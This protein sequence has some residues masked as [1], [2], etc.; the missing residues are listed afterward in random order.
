MAGV[1]LGAALAAPVA[2]A[3]SEPPA[4]VDQQP[5]NPVPVTSND[6]LAPRA[7]NSPQVAADPTD[8]SFLALASRLDAP[9]FSCA[10]HV[11]G[12]GGRSWIPV[13]PV[14]ALPEGAEKCYAPEVAFGP[15]GRLFYLFVGLHGSGNEPMGVFLV[16][17]TDRGRSFSPPR[18]VL[19]EE[20]YQ[21]RLAID[22][23][24]GQA[25]RLYLAWLQA[26]A[27]APLGGLPPPPNPI[28]ASYSDDG[29]QS[30]SEPIRVSDPDRD[31]AVAPALSVAGNGT[32]HV[33]YLDLRE[34]LRDYR[35]VEGPVY[36]GTWSVVAT[37]ST[38]GGKTFAGGVVVDDGLVPA[39]RVML[40]FTMPPP[41][42]TAGQGGRVHVGWD[43]ARHGD[44]DVFVATSRDAGASW[45]D[46]VRV[47][48]DE[49]G[50]GRAQYLPQI[51]VGRD[52]RLH[53]IFYDR[54]HDPTNIFN[55]IAYTYSSDGGR[56][57]APTRRLTSHP[58]DSRIGQGY[59]VVSAA[60]LIEFGSRL[61][62]EAGPDRVVAAWT[63]T[64]NAVAPRHQDVFAASIGTPTGGLGPWPWVAAVVVLAA[65]AT[66]LLA[67]RRDRARPPVPNP[68]DR[69]VVPA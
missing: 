41:A 34:D 64:S 9:D 32:V 6:I 18:Q 55:H 36:E 40:I 11:S 1:A 69:E 5:A 57:F 27:D 66:V 23:T 50:N 22:H 54:R 49:V 15:D 43:D 26:T 48:D 10:L 47:H 4:S 19:G 21:V 14:P 53:A 8:A 35:G 12:D 13:E 28:L 17:S 33:A 38:D 59:R 31:L 39:E 16:T 51:D 44:R 60:G 20:N 30:W 3:A 7:N 45:S 63:D 25:G 68:S 24:R 29:G 62:L 46:P 67:V 42:I 61:G 52:G 65:A 2:W 37:S 58:S 56:G